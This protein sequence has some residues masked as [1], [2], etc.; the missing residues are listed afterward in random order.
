MALTRSDRLRLQVCDCGRQ[1]IPGSRA[2][3]K[4]ADCEKNWTERVS[5]LRAELGT[6]KAGDP[7]GVW[8]LNMPAY[9]ICKLL[10]D[11]LSNIEKLPLQERSELLR[12]PWCNKKELE[13][14]H[15]AVDA[16][17]AA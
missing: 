12:R 2:S 16:S 13:Y 11:G 5:R 4:H 3:G 17:Q 6:E 10:E 14:I 15:K 7:R 8:T 1:F 9:I